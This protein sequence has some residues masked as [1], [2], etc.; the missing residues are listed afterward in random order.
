MLK[1][2]STKG[3]SASPR[4]MT[5]RRDFLRRLA[6]GTSL[7]LLP[8]LSGAAA[9]EP[10]ATPWFQ[11]SLAQWSLHRAFFSGRAVAIN[12][13]VMARRDFG[14][15]AIEYVNQFYRDAMGP[16]LV[17]ELVRRSRGEG[18]RNVLI[19]CDGEGAVGDPDPA[20]RERT[21]RNHLKWL[22]A[23]R[24]LGCHAIRVNAASTG[25]YDEQLRLAADGLR[26]LAA[27]AELRGLHVLVE[28]HG[29]LSSSGAWLSALMREVDHPRCG[30][31]PD[32]GN[33][34][35]SPTERYD[36]YRGVTE[37]MP[38][39]RGVSA[40]THAFTPD[41]AEAELDYPRLLEIV[42]RAGYRGYVGI[43]YEGAEPEAEG[44]RATRALLERLGGVVD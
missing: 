25:S 5:T 2:R 41:G 13:A 18:V 8:T 14:I 19:M 15:G 7:T 21:V 22:D 40:K 17:A 12:F 24:E 31:L 28:N 26:R 29:G 39:A 9:D 37:L 42:R 4:M 11:I 44:V 3:R 43:E 10:A 35:I 16:R 33:F 6:G 38:Y 23:A 30:T 27:E 34:T 20:A 36:P 1:S 32:F